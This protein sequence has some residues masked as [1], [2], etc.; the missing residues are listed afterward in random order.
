MHKLEKWALDEIKFKK[1][2]TLLE[3]NKDVFWIKE[4]IRDYIFQILTEEDKEKINKDDFELIEWFIETKSEYVKIL[5]KYREDFSYKLLDLLSQWKILEEFE[6]FCNSKNIRYVLKYWKE[7]NLEYVI[8]LC[9][10]PEEI[11]ALFDNWSVR[12]VLINWQEIKLLYFIDLYQIKTPEEFEALCNNENI[13]NIVK[14]WKEK[15]LEYVINLYQIKTS[16]DFEELFNNENTKDVLI[17]WKEKNLEYVI[18]LYQIKTPEEFEALCNNENIKAVLE[19]WKEKNLEYVIN[20]CR[21]PEDFEEFYKKMNIYDF[22]SILK[23]KIFSSAIINLIWEINDKQKWKLLEF[24]NKKVLSSKQ[25]IRIFFENNIKPWK[26]F[27]NFFFYYLENKQ[28]SLISTLQQLDIIKYLELNLDIEKFKT[29]YDFVDENWKIDYKKLR[30]NYE[31]MLYLNWINEQQINKKLNKF[32]NFVKAK[33]NKWLE[34]ELVENLI[35]YFNRLF[36]EKLK[37]KIIS[38]IKKNLWNWYIDFN[39]ILDE[40]IN[41]PFFIEA[42]KISMNPKYNKKHIDK[43]L[44]KYLKWEFDKPLSI[45]NLNQYNTEKNKEWLEEK[46]SKEQQEI[47]LSKNEIKIDLENKEIKNKD[48][49]NWNKEDNLKQN[50]EARINHHLEVAIR[51]IEDIN[52]LW[53]EFKTKWFDWW[54]LVNYF[55][56]TIN[57]E[58]NKIKEKNENLYEDLKLQTK[59]IEELFIKRKAKKANSI[60][61]YKEQDPLKTLMM[62]NWVEGSCLSYYNKVKNYYSVISNTIDVNKWVFYIRNEKWE[63][64]WRCLVTIWNDK[65]LSRYKM[66][67]SWNVNIPID[68][69]FDEYIKS[70]AKKMWLKLNWDEDEVKNI[71]C[72]DWYPDWIKEV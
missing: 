71:E 51:K 5:K 55:N 11:K 54:K 38:E 62:W 44:L 69:Y 8:S 41:N 46:L 47:W 4:Y 37:I 24:I 7:K 13:R 66:Y 63:L 68:S 9:K 35:K 70:L 10:T 59:L 43:L 23:D 12:Y 39:E 16:E 52:K 3:E 34:K 2:K 30:K 61:I 67:Y 33:N 14:W 31:K 49:E 45:D 50:I 72:D 60:T 18:N 58:K 56:W 53:F 57:K 17:W 64:L 28:K 32:N 27:N 20:L 48:L 1:I 42:F 29:I 26:I 25:N 36:N 65:K 6:D 19:E 22:I 21:T 15:N 40:K